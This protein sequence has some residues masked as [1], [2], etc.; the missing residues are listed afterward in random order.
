[1]TLLRLLARRLAATL[2]LVLGAATLVFV[3]LEAAP[4]EPVDL[5]LGERPVPQYVRAHIERAYGLDRPALDRYG[6]WLGGVFLRG[7]L[8]WSY[9]RSRPVASLLAEALP[10][11]LLLAG[12]ALLLHV[13]FGIVLGG[14]SVAWRARAVERVL[15]VGSLLLYAMPTFSVGLLAIL[16][17]AHAVPLFPAS[18]MHSVGAEGWSAG[19]RLFDL[20]RHLCLPAL[21]LGAASAAGMARFVR[22]GLLD[23]MREEFIRAGRARGLGAGRLLWRHALR[24][25]LLP[26]V[27][28]AGLSLPI[29]VS[30]SLVTEVVFAWPG[31]GRL[32]YE[33]ILA[34]DVPIVLATT[35]LASWLVVAGSLVADLAMLAVDP[36]IR[37]ARAGARP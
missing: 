35:I 34:R 17:L 21:V 14:L 25:A 13:V 26:V 16:L 30:G 27:N 7:D 5:L 23:T 6:S 29:L 12:A 9:S 1:V 37:L 28:L 22:A 19:A 18:S 4:G 33:A 31:M 32:T 20:L 2:P 3:A 11:T 10:A 24:N 8:G 36:R 15:T